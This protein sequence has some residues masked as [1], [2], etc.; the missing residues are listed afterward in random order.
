MIPQIIITIDCVKLQYITRLLFSL[1]KWSALD[2]W[3]LKY[4]CDC[5]ISMSFWNIISVEFLNEKVFKFK[6]L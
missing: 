3:N 4:N 5:E 6:L 1:T 2:T